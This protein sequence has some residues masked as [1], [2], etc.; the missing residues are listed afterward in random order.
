MF[1]FLIYQGGD[2]KTHWPRNTYF[3]PQQCGIIY[4]ENYIVTMIMVT[5]Y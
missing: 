1:I 4:E 2:T 3:Y 5:N